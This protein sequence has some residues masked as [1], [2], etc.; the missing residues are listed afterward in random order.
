V[1]RGGW[2][3]GQRLS[4]GPIPGWV[5]FPCTRDLALVRPRAEQVE[6]CCRDV[7]FRVGDCRGRVGVAETVVGVRGGDVEG[8]SDFTSSCFSA[9][10]LL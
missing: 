9:G 8:V 10:G 4:S 3:S 5:G 7:V 1:S 6:H 2:G